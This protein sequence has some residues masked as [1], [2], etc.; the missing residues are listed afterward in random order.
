[1]W[2]HLILYP[3]FHAQRCR[4][5][6]VWCKFCVFFYYLFYLSL[7]FGKEFYY[8]YMMDILVRYTKP[9]L[10][11]PM[12]SRMLCLKL[13]SSPL[14]SQSLY[15]SVLLNP[16]ALLD[17]LDFC[18]TFLIPVF[19]WY[20]YYYYDYDWLYMIFNKHHR[21]QSQL[22]SVILLMQFCHV[23]SWLLLLFYF[24]LSTFFYI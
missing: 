11:V 16:T 17:V 22:C 3:V 10:I 1:M 7:I 20:Y 5:F 9:D 4:I 13:F 18:L 21:K 19:L 24:L 6:D 15:F 12:Y 23:L 2:S 8:L 14:F